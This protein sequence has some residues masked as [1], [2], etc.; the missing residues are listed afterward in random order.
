MNA[1]R[2][3]NAG[4]NPIE[5]AINRIG[6]TVKAAK[7]L[8]ISRPT[9]LAWRKRGR[10][11]TDAEFARATRLAA[12]SGVPLQELVVGDGTAR[13]SGSGTQGKVAAAE[14]PKPP[15]RRSTPARGRER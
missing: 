3:A 6:N 15:R 7:V 13:D 14:K 8:G 9:L 12:L 10:I 1:M 11:L 5:A 4:Y 2:K